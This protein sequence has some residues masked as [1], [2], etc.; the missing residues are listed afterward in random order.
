MMADQTNA[1]VILGTVAYMSPEQARGKTVD[2]RTDIWAFGCVLYQML[3][4]RLAFRGETVSDTIVAILE[5]EADWTALPAGTPAAVRRLQERC[6]EKD[7]RRRLRDIG[8]V[9]H[10]LEEPHRE[11]RVTAATPSL[12]R[13]LGWLV[14]GIAL[15]SAV[16]AGWQRWSSPAEAPV[17]NVQLHRL[18]DFV[19]M[20]DSP[21]ISPDGKTVAFVARAGSKRQIFVRLLAGGAPLQITRDD[22]TTSGPVGAGLQFPYLLC[23]AGLRRAR[24]GL[25]NQRPGRRAKADRPCAQRR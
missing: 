15:A 5:R 4:G 25:G 18:T 6:L 2:K 19:G 9:R 10:W 20:E 3:T 8:D 14:G 16:F 13:G 24:H 1:G 17:I 22:V 11:P 21:A 23:A 7:S 12:R